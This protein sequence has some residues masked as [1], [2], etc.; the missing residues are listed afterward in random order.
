MLPVPTERTSDRRS[1][2]IGCRSLVGR[3]TS[4]Y[5]PSCDPLKLIVDINSQVAL[6][7]DMLIHVGQSKDCPELREKIRKIR[8]SLV[9]ACR[10]TSSLI[11]PQIRT[12]VSEGIVTDNP[13]LVLLF[14]LSQLFLRELIKSYR[15]VQVIPMDMSGYYENRAGPSNLGNVISQILLCKQ[16][17]PDFNQEELCSI[18]KDSQEIAHLLAEMQEF[19]PQQEIYLERNAALT[20]DDT[21]GPWP[22]KRRRNSLYKNMG[23]LCCVSRPNYL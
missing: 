12:A 22:A 16:I 19:M 2:S 11:L 9:E 17:T 23:L 4:A 10:H 14:Y 21:N 20:G 18:N 3:R 13:H 15:L 6:F 8:F 1:S 7:R 5:V